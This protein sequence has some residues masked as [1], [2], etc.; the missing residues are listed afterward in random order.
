MSQSL[1]RVLIHII[2]S[3]KNRFA[4]FTDGE[5]QK[6]MHAYLARVFNEQDSPTI[7][8]GGTEDHVHILCLLSRKHAISDVIKEVK[9][10]SSSWAKT[11]GGRCMKFSWQSGYG[12]F[13]IN[14]SQI[15]PLRKYIQAR[16]NI[17]AGKVSRRSI[18]SFCVSTRFLTMRG[19]FGNK[20]TK[21]CA[22]LSGLVFAHAPSQ[23]FAL[24]FAVSPLL[25]LVHL[26]SPH[27]S[28]WD[29]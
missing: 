1:S 25:R 4:F 3:T 17:I 18:W 6:R 2:F 20:L 10:N 27:L 29:R 7:E 12:A 22:A 15:E 24:G 16:R 21:T 26:S 8:V 23:G 11:L 14:Q 28:P 13:S 9:V 19:I 5:M